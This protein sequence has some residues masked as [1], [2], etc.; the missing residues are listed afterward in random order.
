VIRGKNKRVSS[1]TKLRV[2]ARAYIE[3][4]SSCEK[5]A[6]EEGVSCATV[7]R[8]HDI[9]RNY[10]INLFEDRR[11]KIRGY[12]RVSR[13]QE[14]CKYDNDT[15]EESEPEWTQDDTTAAK[16][17]DEVKK[18]DDSDEEKLY[19]LIGRLKVENDLLRI[20]KETEN[21]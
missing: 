19:A 1:E 15:L 16:D 6:S 11:G 4:D 21:D 5:I 17:I 18:I 9:M 8:C 2:G 14:V 20:K 10:G 7:Y 13:E 12:L 3:K